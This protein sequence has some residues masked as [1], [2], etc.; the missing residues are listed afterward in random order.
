[1]E[2]EKKTY[3]KS[4]CHLCGRQD[5]CIETSLTNRHGDQVPVCEECIKAVHALCDRNP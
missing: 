3:G 4:W 2:N 1:M 5:M